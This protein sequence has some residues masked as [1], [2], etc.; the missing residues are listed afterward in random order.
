MLRFELGAKLLLREPLRVAL[1][2]GNAVVHAHIHLVANGHHALG[3]GG[4]ILHKQPDGD[5]QVVDIVEDESMLVGV[6]LLAPQERD[7]VLAPMT[8]GV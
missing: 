2:Q 6:Q 8:A 1:E 7:G 4:V 5:H 3:E